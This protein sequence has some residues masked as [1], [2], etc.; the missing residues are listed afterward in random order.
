MLGFAGLIVN[1]AVSG[2]RRLH[3]VLSVYLC[4][5]SHLTEDALSSN[6]TIPLSVLQ[7]AITLNIFHFSSCL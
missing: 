3:T 2:R 7:A 4:R 5:L 1:F 6:H